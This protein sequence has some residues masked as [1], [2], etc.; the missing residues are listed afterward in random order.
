MKIK[1][2]ESKKIKLDKKSIYLRKLILLC[3]KHQKRGHV[4]PAMSLVEIIRILYKR[5]I[6]KNKSKFILS[7]GH[8]CLALYAVLYDKGFIKKKDLLSIG[9]FNSNL[10][11]HPEHDKVNGVEISTGALGHGLPIAVGMAL[12]SKIN[13]NNKNYFVVCGDGE[14]NEGSIWE[15]LLS[16]SKHKLDNLILLI[17]YNKLQSYGKTR[18]ILNLEP[19]TDKFNSFNFKTFNING[20]DITEIESTLNKVLKIKNKPSVIICHT[21]KGKGLKIAE[22]NPH[23]HH[24]SFLE[25]NDLSKLEKS[26]GN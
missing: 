4:G 6:K 23:W 14:I 7:K 21:I 5:F 25:E 1:I 20:H 15:S 12:A 26:L 13:K 16:A 24:K 2:F 18:D 10:G 8:G 17:D 9:K 22:G 3:L 19:L 11:G